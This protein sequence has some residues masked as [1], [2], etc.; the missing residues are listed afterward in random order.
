MLLFALPLSVAEAATAP[1]LETACSA[2]RGQDPAA[3][4]QRVEKRLDGNWALAVDTLQK[5]IQRQRNLG[6]NPNRA[7]QYLQTLECLKGEIDAGQHQAFIAAIRQGAALPRNSGRS[8]SGQNAKP[9]IIVPPRVASSQAR[10]Q[11]V[12]KTNPRGTAATEQVEEARAE[13]GG[14][15]STAAPT[16][17]PPPSAPSNLAVSGTAASAASR[18]SDASTAAPAAA[19]PLTVPETAPKS[20]LA[21]A[22]PAREPAA[23]R[24]PTILPGTAESF[25][26]LVDDIA[27]SEATA[28]ISPG[29]TAP[30]SAAVSGNQTSGS[31]GA[32]ESSPYAGYA[33]VYFTR[34]EYELINGIA[35]RNRYS[36]GDFVCHE[37]QMLSC[38]YGRWK[39]EGPCTGFTNWRDVTSQKLEAN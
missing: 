38:T 30:Q 1:P 11:W 32:G 17:A 10:P 6:Q 7:T 29:T 39:S 15:A 36:E 27:E 19:A 3:I 23:P 8:N 20:S 28:P 31:A 37:G 33:C 9:K 34:P 16:S 21:A 18:T 12:D 35:K 22:S 2:P 26:T 5:T 14:V 4:V 24:E 25:G 13:G